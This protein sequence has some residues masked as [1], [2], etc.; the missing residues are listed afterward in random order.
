MRDIVAKTFYK[1]FITRNNVDIM[2]ASEDYH[3]NEDE[4]DD[5]DDVVEIFIFIGVN[6]SALLNI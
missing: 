1:F 3:R 5:D 4:D 6:L 2:T